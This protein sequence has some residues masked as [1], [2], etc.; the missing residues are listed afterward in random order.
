MTDDRTLL[1]RAARAADNDAA[2]I[3]GALELADVL[4]SRVVA[5][6]RGH[7]TDAE[8]RKARNALRAHL[9]RRA[10]AAI[11]GEGDE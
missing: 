1:E 4:A 10:A 5:K 2:W 11:A 9:K 8:V 7:V 6:T 3:T